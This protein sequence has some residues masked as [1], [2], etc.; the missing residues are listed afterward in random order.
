MAPAYT[1]LC[2]A[3]RDIQN[4]IAKLARLQSSQHSRS[5]LVASIRDALGMLD[6]QLAVF[7]VIRWVINPQELQALNT[8]VFLSATPLQLA[9]LADDVR[10]Y[11][12][13]AALLTCSA[14][15]NYRRALLQS[16]H[17]TLKASRDS[18]LGSSLRHRTYRSTPFALTTSHDTALSAASDVTTSLRRT[19]ALM[20]TELEKSAFT[21]Q[22]LESSS[23]TLEH[24][25]HSYSHF[26]TLLLGSKKLIRELEKQDWWDRW[27]VYL[28]LAFFC[29]VCAYILIRRIFWRICGVF[30]YRFVKLIL[31]T[32]GFYDR[33][34]DSTV[35]LAFAS[36]DLPE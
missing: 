17:S 8:H 2:N 10:M 6:S 19:H 34:V 30:V 28:S 12:V 22:V 26:H 31:W 27:M 3:L 15:R 20:T 13:L 25:Q 29:C 32:F 9:A 16:E 35:T 4:Q 18:L 14:R 5:A 24:L 21:S 23:K 33:R 11:A 36:P 7:H 1:A